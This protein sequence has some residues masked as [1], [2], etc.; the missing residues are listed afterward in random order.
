MGRGR[1]GIATFSVEIQAIV[2]IPVTSLSTPSVSLRAIGEK[3]MFL[4][5]NGGI[6][7]GKRLEVFRKRWE[8]RYTNR[9]KADCR[10]GNGYIPVQ[11]EGRLREYAFSSFT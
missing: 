3:A 8:S 5:R 4:F 1:G 10:S 9:E 7:A 2:F 6:A 11:S